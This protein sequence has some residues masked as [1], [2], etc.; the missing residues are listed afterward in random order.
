VAKT[1]GQHLKDGSAGVQMLVNAGLFDANW[2]KL[3]EEYQDQNIPP[4]K[5]WW[6]HVAGNPEGAWVT[7]GA[8]KV[9]PTHHLPEAAHG[10]L[11]VCRI[12]DTA[13]PVGVRRAE[14]QESLEEIRAA[15]ARRN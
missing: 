10:C 15:Q 5:L 8:L 2:Q 6:P 11:I 7:L 9:D 14:W 1:Y 3:Q 12:C 13:K 4:E